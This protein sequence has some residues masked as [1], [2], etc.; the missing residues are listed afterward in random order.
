MACLVR[1]TTTAQLEAQFRTNVLGAAAV[2]RQVLPV[3]RNRRSGTIVNVSSLA[4]RMAAP[5]MSAYHATKFALEG[6]SESLWFELSLHGIRVK[7]VEPAHFKT[8]FLERSLQR[9]SHPAYDAPFENYMG[10]VLK[11]AAKAPGPQPVAEA[12][13]RAANDGSARLRYPVGGT[14]VRALCALVP[15]SVWRSL[16]A[17]GMTRPSK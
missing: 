10:W 2:I 7:I 3:M 17:A 6:L 13:Y 16:N 8:S 14:L 1:W 15:G 4:G 9:T 12:I 11:E 5:F